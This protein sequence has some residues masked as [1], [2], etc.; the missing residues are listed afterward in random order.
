MTMDAIGIEVAL[1][2]FLDEETVPGSPDET[3]A[4]FRLI[5]SP[6]DEP[7][8]EMVMPCTATTPALAAAVL[9]DLVPGDQLRITGYLRL[10]RTPDEPMWLDV[11][12]D[13]LWA[14]PLSAPTR[15][16]ADL[17]AQ[18]IADLTDLFDGLDLDG[19]T[20]TVLDETRPGARAKVIRALG[21]MF[22]DI[23]VPGID[24]TDQ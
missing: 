21:D 7:V 17:D 5:V 15:G 9:H 16:P 13:V 3:S 8:D 12:L 19:L 23:P 10:P 14:A 24:D 2:G 20:R 4:R 11:T 6:T 22:G 1:D 18:T